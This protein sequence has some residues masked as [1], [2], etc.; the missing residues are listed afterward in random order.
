MSGTDVGEL[1]FQY[2]PAD[3][4]ENPENPVTGSGGKG[5]AAGD[6]MET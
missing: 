5:D 4:V 6:A 3:P 2:Y 1:H